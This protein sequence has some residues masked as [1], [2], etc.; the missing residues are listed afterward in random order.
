ME[1]SKHR[2]YGYGGIFTREELHTA[3]Q[4]KEH[5]GENY[6]FAQHVMRKRKMFFLPL[7]PRFANRC[8][9]DQAT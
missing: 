3:L 9:H 7:Y 6:I 5:T 1:D 4:E 2:C 8:L